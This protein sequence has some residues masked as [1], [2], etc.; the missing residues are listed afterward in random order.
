MSG[1]RHSIECVL[2]FYRMCFLYVGRR[3]ERYVV[4]AKTSK[5]SRNAGIDAGQTPAYKTKAVLASLEEVG[6]DIL[7][8]DTHT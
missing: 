4:D 1:M 5:S 3:C 2:T 6:S 8:H 7:T